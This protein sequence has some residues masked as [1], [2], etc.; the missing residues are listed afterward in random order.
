ML[1]GSTTAGQ[2]RRMAWTGFATA[3]DDCAG[4]GEAASWRGLGYRRPDARTHV[5][6]RCSASVRPLLVA[7]VLL[8]AA[9]PPAGAQWAVINL[10][11]PD[12]GVFDSYALCIQDGQQSGYIRTPGSF[13]QHAAVWSGTAASF[14]DLNPPGAIES[15][16]TTVSSGQQAG[17]AWPFDPPAPGG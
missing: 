5:L 6:P 2:G 11:P 16:A 17:W 15:I 10:H 7:S 9:A 4:L 12:P 1:A 3:V 13:A 8:L 14:I